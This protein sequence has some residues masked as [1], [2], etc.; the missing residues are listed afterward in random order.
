MKT[1]KIPVTWEVYGHME[2]KAESLED[3]ISIAEDDE[4]SLPTES[5]YI[6]G[7]FWVDREAIDIDEE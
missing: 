7:S 1:Y 5:S 2:I 3:A 4:T 6:E